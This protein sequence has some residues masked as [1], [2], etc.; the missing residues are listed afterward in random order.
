VEVKAIASQLQG[1]SA[2]MLRMQQG[3]IHRYQRPDAGYLEV[4][5]LREQLAGHGGLVAL[6]KKGGNINFVLQGQYRSPGLNLNDMGYIREADFVGEGATMSYE[7]NDPGKWIR[8]YTLTLFQEARWSFGGEHTGNELGSKFALMFNKLWSFNLFYAYDF[9]HLS[10]RE[11]RGGP[12]L[13]MDGEHKTGVYISSDRAKNLSGN[14]G[15][16]FN[17]YS[18]I[19]SHSEV[20]HAGM[21]WLPIRKIRLSGAA[22]LET[23]NYH[24]QYVNT[25]MGNTETLYLTGSI[26]QHTTSFTFRGEL[27][28]SPELSL[29]YYGS[30]FYSVGTYANFRRVDQSQAKE[31][32]S[33]LKAVD[34]SYDEAEN[35]YSFAYNSE[36]WNFPNPDFSFMQFRS[37]LVFRWEYKLGSTLYLV[38]AHDRSGFERLYNPIPDISGDLFGIQGNHVFMFKLNFWFSI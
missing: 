20:L 28:L 30:P 13:R 5:S 6:G 1:S 2:S 7:M 14:V 31:M 4:D 27:F 25:L 10:I 26:D 9:N 21:T 33:R 35:G 18:G 12:A 22:T 24:Q 36:T 23:R 8:N 15:F 16:H 17:T 11:L 29:Q 3:P 32:E 38:W 37:N 34:V 19:A